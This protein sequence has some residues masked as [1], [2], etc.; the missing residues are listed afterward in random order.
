MRTKYEETTAELKRA[1]TET[2]QRLGVEFNGELR[3]ILSEPGQQKTGVGFGVEIGSGVPPG[4]RG[5]RDHL[6]HACPQPAEDEDE[7]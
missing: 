3:G 4:W 1:I 2:C 6:S 7:D 5:H